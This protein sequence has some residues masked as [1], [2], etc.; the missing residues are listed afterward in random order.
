M[1]TVTHGLTGWLVAR[2][3]P[4]DWKGEHPAIATGVVAIGSVLP[5]ADNAASLLGSELYLRVHRGLSHSLLGISVSSLVL[6]MLFAY[7]GK[8]KD[9]KR[10]FLLAL[11]GQVSHVVLDLL[12][13]YGTQVLQPFSDARLSLDLLFVVD[14]VFT[15]I[16][17]AGIVLSR[18]GRGGRARVAMA[19]LAVYVGIAA[20]LHGR[21]VDLVRD[22]A[23][24]AGVTVVTASAL[25]E[26]P[27]V[28]LPSIDRLGFATPAAASP[29]GMDLP[30]DRA[31]SER[32]AVP[33][34]A[35][36]FAWNGFVDD[37]RTFL[38]A[39]VDPVMGTLEWKQRE[40]RGIDVPA[41]RAVRG[42]ADVETYLWFARFPAA[43]VV[44]NQGRTEVTFYDMRFSGMPGRRP[45]LLRVTETPGV[46]PRA[47]WGT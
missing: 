22:A 3:L 28:Q 16:V 35:G 12:N 21:A 4:D 42:L 14:L 47:R 18:A 27:F 44:S 30:G 38:R 6:A 9:A 43:S 39:E 24:R 7:F 29:A 25:P 20:L 10:L 19:S 15:G 32:R 31:A 33:F 26:L 11:L 13:A 1:D 40:V 41:V 45:F 36:P 17:V 2:A 5:D 37:G 46:P 8:C 23:V 34:P